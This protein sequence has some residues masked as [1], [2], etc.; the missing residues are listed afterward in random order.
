MKILNYKISYKGKD[1]SHF[2]NFHWC[3]N[4]IA[5]DKT[6]HTEYLR[7]SCI[8]TF[9]LIIK[10]SILFITNIQ[11]ICFNKLFTSPTSSKTKELWLESCT[12]RQDFWL[13]FLGSH[14]LSV[15]ARFPGIT[16]LLRFFLLLVLV[17]LSVP[18]CSWVTR[19]PGTKWGAFLW[20]IRDIL[21]AGFF[22]PITFCASAVLVAFSNALFCC[23]TS[24]F[25]WGHNRI[26]VLCRF[27]SVSGSP[28]THLK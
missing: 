18:S 23:M 2:Q 22:Q 8:Q 7:N 6:T 25:A 14:V 17:S 4:L 9:N 26:S 28:C 24:V 13:V 20:A 12:E 15:F 10:F 19:G 1:F 3:F 21:S 11:H 27:H 5:Q 16:S